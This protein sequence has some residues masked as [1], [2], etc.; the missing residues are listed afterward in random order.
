MPK[1]HTLPASI[2]ETAVLLGRERYIADRT[3]AVVVYL[4]LQM[5][6]PLF[7]EGEAGVGKTEI[8][9]ALAAGLGRELIRLQ[10]YEGLD[11]NAALYEWNHLRQ[12]LELKLLESAAGAE[13]SK[14]ALSRAIFTP[15]FLLKRPLLRAL[16]PHS[17]GAPVLLIDEI[18]RADEPF[19]AFLLE[20]LADFQVTIPELGVIRA[21]EPP[22]VI[23]T[24]NRTRDVHDALK[25]RCLYHWV[26]YPDAAREMQI[27]AA[28]APEVNQALALQIVDYTQNLRRRSLTKPP[29]VAE[30]ID[31]AHAI[32]ALGAHS[33]TPELIRETLG[34]L[35]KYEEDIVSVRATLPAA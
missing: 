20:L 28:R 14:E 8:A 5:R 35:L 33:L 7:L 19:E 4:A 17:S 31:W 13:R 3:L 1:L 18:D 32:V 30:S 11:S 23:V 25:R 9:K 16:E 22:I 21:A 27:L 2:D 12:L 34:V 26:D 24:S 15:E 29:G 10:C 6:R